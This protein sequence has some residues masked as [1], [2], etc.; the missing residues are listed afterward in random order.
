MS[1]DMKPVQWK[2]RHHQEGIELLTFAQDRHAQVNI[3]HQAAAHMQLCP[4]EAVT[5]M[6]EIAE[7]R[8]EHGLWP[9]P[10]SAV[11]S[12]MCIIPGSVWAISSVTGRSLRRHACSGL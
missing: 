12:R 1:S 8:A 9:T 6:K 4:L 2:P 5:S 7:S 3:S 10:E 11:S